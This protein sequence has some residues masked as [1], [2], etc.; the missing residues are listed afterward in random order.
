MNIDMLNNLHY[1]T[2]YFLICAQARYVKC[3]F[4]NNHKH[5][6]RLKISLLFKKFKNLTHI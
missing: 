2:L 4:T 1:N 5:Q 3:L 6:N